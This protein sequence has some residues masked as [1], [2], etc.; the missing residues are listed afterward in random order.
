MKGPSGRPRT[1][2]GP[3]GDTHRVADLIK[4]ADPLPPKGVE[5][6]GAP[7]VLLKGARVP[8]PVGVRCG[9]RAVHLA[10]RPLPH[11]PVPARSPAFPVPG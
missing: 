7:A 6:G 10:V 11:V 3:T 4:M 9:P 2:R 1:H 5:Q 8:V